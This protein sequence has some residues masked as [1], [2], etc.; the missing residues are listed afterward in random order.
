MK[1]III[2]LLVTSC[3]SDDSSPASDPSCQ[4][5]VVGVWSGQSLS[6][7]LTL[8]ADRSFSYKGDDGCT[9]RGTYSCPEG[10][11]GTLKIS[12]DS[13]ELSS[14]CLQAGDHTCTYVIENDELAYTCNDNLLFYGRK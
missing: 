7:E 9:T 13:A 14:Y 11:R 10:E 5:P 4:S 12:I 1:Y 2:L 6:D 8:N 3:G